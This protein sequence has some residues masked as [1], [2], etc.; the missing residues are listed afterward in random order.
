MSE[1]SISKEVKTTQIQ[2]NRHKCSHDKVW[3]HNHMTRTANCITDLPATSWSCSRE[4]GI[5]PARGERCHPSEIESRSDSKKQ[6]RSRR[7]HCLND[8]DTS[9]RLTMAL[10]DSILKPSVCRSLSA[11]RGEKKRWMT[12][13]TREQKQKWG[14]LTFG[15]DSV[16]DGPQLTHWDL[17]VLSRDKTV[18]ALF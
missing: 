8:E 11:N 13:Q 16:Q 3:T 18:S 10:Q 5:Q 1:P 14:K 9:I 7:G 17:H 2:S 4:S 6:K 15:Y 12:L